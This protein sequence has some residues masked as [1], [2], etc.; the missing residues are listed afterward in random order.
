MKNKRPKDSIF[1]NSIKRKQR[2]QDSN[3]N[4]QTFNNYFYKKGENESRNHAAAAIEPFFTS[5]EPAPIRPNYTYKKG[6]AERT[7][8]YEFTNSR[9]LYFLGT[10]DPKS[11][12]VFVTLIGLL[13]SE[14]LNAT[15]MKIVYAFIS[16]IGDTIL[17]L[18][19]QEVILQNFRH[20]EDTRQLGNALDHDLKTIYAQLDKIKRKLPKN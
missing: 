2:K 8:L 12:L 16:N 10:L 4:L 7:Y 5:E 6:E 17:T 9:F 20:Q 11:Y 15:E 1:H 18:L 14:D 13:I 19:E 3:R